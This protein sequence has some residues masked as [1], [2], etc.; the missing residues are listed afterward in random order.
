M[1][2]SVLTTGKVLKIDHHHKRCTRY[3]LKP[4]VIY[5]ASFVFFLGTQVSSINK[6]L[7]GDSSENLFE[8]FLNIC[9]S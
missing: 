2:K 1:K 9:E 8:V 3:S 6:D 4:S 7:W 5:A